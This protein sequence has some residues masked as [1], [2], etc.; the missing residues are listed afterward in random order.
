[1]YL[2]YVSA[3]QQDSKATN[4]PQQQTE[5]D[6]QPV[7]LALTRSNTSYFLREAAT[8]SI[9]NPKPDGF[10]DV[11]R[12]FVRLRECKEDEDDDALSTAGKADAA[13]AE[14]QLAVA[15]ATIYFCK[16]RIVPQ[17]QDFTSY[18]RERSRLADK[19]IIA[20]YTDDDCSMS[21][22]EFIAI[23]RAAHV[24][25]VLTK[26]G[27]D[28]PIVAIARPKCCFADK[29]KWSRRAEVIALFTGPS[30]PD[31]EEHDQPA[32]SPS[33]STRQSAGLA[34]ERWQ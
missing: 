26:E 18:I 29:A 34:C 31:S 7:M 17:R 21:Q 4:L 6:L 5:H 33:S 9:D 23:S 25:E 8:K 1:M 24:R 15:L 14:T 12:L 28:I 13:E 16:G 20:G 10:T 11:E 22:S 3:K 27:I 30:G 19:L 32:S 2:I